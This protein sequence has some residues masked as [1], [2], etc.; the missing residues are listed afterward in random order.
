MSSSWLHCSSTCIT[1]LIIIDMLKYL[2]AKGSK[3]KFFVAKSSLWS[4]L[5]HAC[6]CTLD[7]CIY[8]ISEHRVYNQERR[9]L[10]TPPAALTLLPWV[11]GG[12]RGSQ[13]GFRHT[14][15]SFDLAN[16]IIKVSLP[17]MWCNF[18]FSN[19][20]RGPLFCPHSYIIHVILPV[21]GLWCSLL[22]PSFE[23]FQSLLG[24]V[25]WPG[26]LDIVY[27]DI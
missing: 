25:P 2:E 17:Y 1:G 15:H 7:N 19:L 16:I 10:Y 12:G 27:F 26:S 24:W 9:Q 5:E 11:E 21:S 13:M 20:L 6:S 23:Y 4:S 14:L 18:E 22:L 8:H 3:I